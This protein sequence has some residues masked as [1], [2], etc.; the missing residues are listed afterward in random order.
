M[1]FGYRMKCNRESMNIPVG[2]SVFH[3]C[4][5][6]LCRVSTTDSQA[7]RHQENPSRHC[8]YGKGTGGS[9]S[10]NHQKGLEV[11]WRLLLVPGPFF[12]FFFF[13]ISSDSD[14]TPYS[15]KYHSIPNISWLPHVSEAP[16][17]WMS[18]W[19]VRQVR[20]G[21]RQCKVK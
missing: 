2:D 4:V 12:F 20:S 21:K 16:V 17:H 19:K 7:S 10:Y 11:A 1:N 6:L 8:P 13:G 18:E 14:R 5:L 3:L 15:P 9:T